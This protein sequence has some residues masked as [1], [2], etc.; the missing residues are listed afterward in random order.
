MKVGA[1]VCDCGAPEALDAEGVREGVAD[2]DVEV[3]ASASHLCGDGLGK[4]AAV[5]D[6]YDLDHVVATAPDAGCQRRIRSMAEGQGLHPDA[7]AFVD[8]REGAG[9]VHDAAAATEK[10]SRLIDATVAG[11][12]E[13]SPSRTVSR[14]AGNHVVVVGDPAAAESLAGRAAKSGTGN[15]RAGAD[16]TLVADGQEF[17]DGDYDFDDITVERGSVQAVEGRFGE[18]ELTLEARVTEECIGCMDCVKL[19]PDEAVTSYPVDIVPDPPDGEYLDCCPVDA[20][21]P[22]GVER[23]IKAD[24]VVYPGG[25][26]KG[27]GGQ[28]GYFSHF[29]GGVAAAVE[30]QLGGITKP[31][32]LD[33]EMD[34]CAA[35]DSGVEGCTRCTDACPHE[36][37]SRPAADEV[38]FDETACMDCGACTSACPTGAVQLREPSNERLAREVESMLDVDSGG[39]LSTFFGGEA[40]IE[41]PVLAFVCSERAED[42]LRTYGRR[43]GRGEDA[44]YDPILPVRVNCTDTVGEAQVLHALAAGADG[45]AIVG[46]GDACLHSG[47][48]PKQE[49]VDRMNVATGDLGLGPRTTFFAPEGD[50]PDGFAAE[51]DAFISGLDPSPLPTGEHEATGTGRPDSARDPF[52]T[53]DWALESLRVILNETDPDRDVIRGLD[54]FGRMEVSD[55]CNLTPTCTTLCP[56]DAIQRTDAGELQFS[57]ADCVNCELCESGCPEGAITMEAGLDRSRL[58]E[59]RDGEAWEPVFE[60]EMLECVR[61]GTPFTSVGSMETVRDEV[62]DLVEGVAGDTEH[63]IFEYCDECRAAVVFQG[64]DD[65]R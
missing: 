43:A 6:E 41:S 5:V 36:A 54:T 24:Q 10:T 52:S 19:G 29:D 22:E 55:D 53:H 12:R 3:V 49:L 8:H 56:T 13:E 61:C 14:D 44:S 60:G 7:T 26:R 25:P 46:C 40:A 33:I 4:A 58:P 20:I 11:L 42:A 27:R 64:V 39:R 63:S 62:G 18:F 17:G 9:W 1:F 30:S 2:E 31:Q 23:T 50:D 21:E 65:G 59:N 32:H 48:D 35:G 28:L 45:V 38:A 16:V 51:L 37:V 34:L 57:H 15:G 47:P